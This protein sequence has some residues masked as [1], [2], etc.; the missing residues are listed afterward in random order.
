MIPSM[1]NNGP[2]D[3][4]GNFLPN[5]GV[6]ERDAEAFRM[7]TRGATLSEIEIALQYSSPQHVSTALKRHVTRI[8]KPAADEYRALM[9]DQLD[10]MYREVMRVLEA[11]HYK[12]SDGRV[13]YHADCDCPVGLDLE[14]CPHWKPLKDTS[15]VLSSVDRLLKIQERRAKLY[16]LDAPVKQKIDV[17]NVTVKVE[18]SDDV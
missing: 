18:G 17:Q 6:A 1:G 5:D 9:D 7:R 14:R 12:V 15:P 10:H 2:R 16:G 13:V 3:G 11:A 8:V 4:Q